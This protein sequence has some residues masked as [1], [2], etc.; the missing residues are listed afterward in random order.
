MIRSLPNILTKVAGRQAV[1]PVA[2]RATLNV[3]KTTA[4]S[5]DFQSI[6]KSSAAPAPVPAA[7]ADPVKRLGP[8]TGDPN[9]KPAVVAPDPPMPTASYTPLPAN[10][11][12][13][14]NQPW[15]PFNKTQHEA[16]MNDWLIGVTQNANQQKLQ[17][18]QHALADWKV[19]DAHCRDLGIAA[20]PA[21][22][23]P[24]LEAVGPMPDGYWFGKN[25]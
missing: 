18:Y 23:A 22:T 25:A 6:L 20:P 24:V 16:K 3:A 11:Q 1:A 13:L 15:D 8:F 2:R 4:A 9:T 12:A 21:P 5:I 10:Q 14:L 7:T 17:L 19:N